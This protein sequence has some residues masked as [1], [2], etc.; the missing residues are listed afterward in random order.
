MQTEISTDE[1]RQVMSR[2]AAAV[3]LI[4]TDGPA[5]CHG[6][7]ATA[8]CSVSDNPPTILAC[9]NRS[10]TMNAKIKANGVMSVNIL[11]ARHRSLSLDFASPD[12]TI[13]E[14]FGLARWKAGVTGAPLLADASLALDCEIASHAEV[15]THSVFFGR[16]KSI[17]DPEEL[18][19]L[20]YYRRDFY[21]LPETSLA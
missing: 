16:L 17:H 19:P 20:L 18:A 2:L 7:T 5:G 6:M 15:E 21:T 11:S 1:F 4:A 13:D 14:R 8:V 3:T 12:L 10:S 9:I